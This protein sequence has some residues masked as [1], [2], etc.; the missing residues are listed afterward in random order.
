MCHLRVQNNTTLSKKFEGN[1][2]ANHKG[3]SRIYMLNEVVEEV[4][5]IKGTTPSFNKKTL[6]YKQG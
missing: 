5:H 4:L 2:F 1:N 6:M 3:Y